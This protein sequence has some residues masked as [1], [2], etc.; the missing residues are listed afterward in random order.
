LLPRE[1]A[2]LL[3]L[4]HPAIATQLN[5][6]HATRNTASTVCAL[7]LHLCAGTVEQVGGGSLASRAAGRGLVAARAAGTQ[8]LVW[9]H[10][11]LRF[12]GSGWLCLQLVPGSPGDWRQHG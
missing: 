8:G 6:Q 9:D 11:V 7:A 4:R 12:G 2:L 10:P 1:P 3:A 5:T